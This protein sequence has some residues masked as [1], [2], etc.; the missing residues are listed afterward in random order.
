[1]CAAIGRVAIF[2][3]VVSACTGCIEAVQKKGATDHYVQGKLL[4]EEGAYDA[5]LE[6]LT[7]AV[8]Q[9]PNLSAAHAAAGDIYRRRGNHEL[10]RLSYELAC[11]TNPYAFRPHYNLGVTYQLLAEAATAFSDIR[12]FLQKAVYVYLRA[13]E[14]DPKD[15][16]TYL[17]T[18][19]CYYQLGKYDLAEQ[20]CRLAT[21][22][23]PRSPEAWCN[24]G[25]IYDSQNRLYDA[26]MAY[27]TSLE[28][29]VHQVPLLMNLAATYLR[30]GRVK[31]ALGAY[32]AAAKEDPNSSLPW[33]QIGLCYF[34]LRE[35]SRAL[36][37]Y[38][39]AAQLDRRNAD[40]YRGIGVIYMSQHLLSRGNPALRDKG[41]AAWHTSL[42]ISPDQ[43]ELRRLVR[44]Y[45]P[46][47]VPPSL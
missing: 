10:A 5:A 44:K 35:Y 14:L 43:D 29:D 30:Q 26:I 23:N 36:E 15:F 18:S 11:E 39:K 7:N 21:R 9:D 8:K 19:A 4:A 42:E 46:S 1:M 45:S 20:Y 32:E 41:L 25:T 38:E 31:T 12:N 6:E 3:V 16:D 24:L 40:A 37:A 33:Q 34:S 2:A 47:T 28:I 22:I 17:N 13:A 27:R